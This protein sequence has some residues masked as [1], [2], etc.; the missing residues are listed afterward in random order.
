MK[1][2]TTLS[3]NIQTKAFDRIG[4]ALDLVEVE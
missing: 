4:L 3:G 2:V 1:F